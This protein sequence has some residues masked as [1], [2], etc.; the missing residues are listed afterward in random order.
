MKN[1][2]RF[3]HPGQALS[4]WVNATRS[5]RCGMGSGKLCRNCCFQVNCDNALHYG[6]KCFT[7]WLQ[8]EETPKEPAP[9][10][11][12]YSDEIISLAK[13]ARKQCV[14]KIPWSTIYP[15]LIPY[16]GEGDGIDDDTTIESILS[17]KCG[18]H[19][20]N[21]LYGIASTVGEFINLS[22]DQI[23]RMRGVGV[24]TFGD[25]MKFRRDLLV[26][27][28]ELDIKSGKLSVEE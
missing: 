17:T 16:T 18:R 21:V 4:E 24:G 15:S 5:G 19:V 1:I 27:M 2:E 13:T 23:R 12:R 26:R 9:D 3:T 8:M 11:T 6:D 25:I 14:E 10:K 20:S 22:D 7:A 28:C